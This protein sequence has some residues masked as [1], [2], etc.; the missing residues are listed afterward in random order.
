MRKLLTASV[1]LATAFATAC[2]AAGCGDE[3]PVGG[4]GQ[5]GPDGSAEASADSATPEDA[6]PNTDGG[7]EDAPTDAAS[8]CDATRPKGQFFEATFDSDCEGWAVENGTIQLVADPRRCGAGACRVCVTGAGG[9][10]VLYKYIPGVSKTNGTFELDFN[11]QDET[12]DAGLSAAVYAYVDGGTQI[13]YGTN[14]L[15]MVPG[16]WS[17]G[18]VIVS[19]TS[20]T[21]EYMLVRIFTPA[22][23]SGCFFID[24]LRMGHF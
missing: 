17:L 7:V 18:Q 10:P 3:L 1:F 20:G 8:A 4:E 21:S 11:V 5:G 16:K 15:T 23:P 14:V 2:W 24:E 13:G 12:I 22:V 6:A 9:Q 19:N